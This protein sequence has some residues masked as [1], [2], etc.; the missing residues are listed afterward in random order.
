M[1]VWYDGYTVPTHPGK[2]QWNRHL[3]GV[4]KPCRSVISDPVG[5]C[6]AHLM[7]E[8]QEGEGTMKKKEQDPVKEEKEEEVIQ[9]YDDLVGC[10]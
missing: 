1:G 3:H 2:C 7:W 5:W 4:W 8:L 10:L 6:G 9:Y